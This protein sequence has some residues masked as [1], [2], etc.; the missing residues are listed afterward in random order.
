MHCFPTCCNFLLA[1]FGYSAQNRVSHPHNR[2]DKIEFYIIG[3]ILLHLLT[4][5]FLDTTRQ[6]R[7]S[8]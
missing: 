5:M 8:I 6:M 7:E 1:L 2:V 3:I 4:V